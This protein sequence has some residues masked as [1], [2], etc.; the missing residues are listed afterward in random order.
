M[1]VG[2][3]RF[4]VSILATIFIVGMGSLFKS[5]GAVEASTV[6]SHFVY[7]GNERYNYDTNAGVNL[8]RYFSN[9]GYHFDGLVT[10]GD[11][12]LLQLSQKYKQIKCVYQIK[13]RI[14]S[15][16]L[17][18]QTKVLENGKNKGTQTTYFVK[19]YVDDRLASV[20]Y[21]DGGKTETIRLDTNGHASKANVA[22]RGLSRAVAKAAAKAAGRA[23]GRLAARAIPVIGTVYD[24]YQ[25]YKYVMKP[26]RT[27]AGTI[28]PNSKAAKK[29]KS[30]VHAEKAAR[31]A[32]ARART[33][34]ARARALRNGKTTTKKWRKL[35]VAVKSLRTAVDVLSRAN[36]NLS[37]MHIKSVHMGKFNRSMRT[38]NRSMDSFD[39]SMNRLNR[40][41]SRNDRFI[42]KVVRQVTKSVKSADRDF[43]KAAE[44]GKKAAITM[45]KANTSWIYKAQR[46]TS[47]P[48]IYSKVYNPV[49]D[50]LIIRGHSKPHAN[51]LITS[52]YCNKIVANGHGNFKVTIKLEGFRTALVSS[53][54]AETKKVSYS[55]SDDVNLSIED[56][57]VVSEKVT[58]SILKP[59]ITRVPKV[60]PIRVGKG[61]VVTGETRPGAK[62]IVKFPQGGEKYGTANTKGIFRIPVGTVGVRDNLEIFVA[63]KT[64][65]TAIYEK[66]KE[67]EVPKKGIF[68]D[69]KEEE[70]IKNAQ[71]MT[72]DELIK[73]LPEGWTARKVFG[74]SDGKP[75]LI[76]K[77]GKVTRIR[78]DGPDKIKSKNS[79]DNYHMHKYDDEKDHLNSSNNI[80]GYKANS[81]HI[82]YDWEKELVKLVIPKSKGF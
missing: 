16:I 13:Q 68:A 1:K 5:G 34:Q 58:R 14:G 8:N 40:S 38:F 27:S 29:M 22:R 56:N 31:T 75:R 25:G 81:G 21:N 66:S 41:I 42:S 55:S 76:I 33:V 44:Y 74:K 79:T 71:N 46:D 35:R 43:A 36:R 10:E 19:N 73:N 50:T 49:E 48:K 80:V 17:S 64:S 37:R 78:I 30:I 53:T 32:R 6:N 52:Y 47:T 20:S 28:A 60:N 62:V 82:P 65:P 72:P 24:V 61:V 4:W 15:S 11:S 63:G 9:E 57:G 45:P 59:D 18:I 12:S 3:L 26:T 23:A 54:A 2:K 7:I 67:E 51:I 69:K 77:K 70:Y 39:S